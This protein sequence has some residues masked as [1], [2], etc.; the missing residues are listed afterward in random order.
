MPF[1]YHTLLDWYEE[2]YHKDFSKYI[3]YLVKS[4]EILCKNYGKIGGF[5]FDGMWDKK[6]ENWQEDRL[7]RPA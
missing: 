6:D 2:S 1:F 3:D 4:M 5:W 7:Y